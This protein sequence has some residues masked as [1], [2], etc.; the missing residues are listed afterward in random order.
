MNEKQ[1]KLNCNTMAKIWKMTVFYHSK[2][3]GKA[4]LLSASKVIFGKRQIYKRAK[5]KPSFLFVEDSELDF[6]MS[7]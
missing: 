2:L 1:L 3:G 7:S 4:T 5:I 6:L